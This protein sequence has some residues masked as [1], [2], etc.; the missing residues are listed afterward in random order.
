MNLTQELIIR[1]DKLEI[2]QEYFEMCYEK[3]TT[4]KTHPHLFAGHI[5]SHVTVIFTRVNNFQ[6]M[7]QKTLLGKKR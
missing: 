5:H 7:P 1:F 4:V 6:I 2:S 3:F